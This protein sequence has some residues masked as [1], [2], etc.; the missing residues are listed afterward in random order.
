VYTVSE[1]TD[2]LSESPDVSVQ[3]TTVECGDY[4]SC[5]G[6]PDVSCF[7]GEAI[8]ITSQSSGLTFTAIWSE[9]SAPLLHGSR[10]I[11]VLPPGGF[12]SE[13][14]VRFTDAQR[15]GGRSFGIGPDF[16]NLEPYEWAEH[17][18]TFDAKFGG[19]YHPV[20]EMLPLPDA[21]LVYIQ[22]LES[23]FV[24]META[25]ICSNCNDES[26]D[27]TKTRD[28]PCSYSDEL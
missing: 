27:A 1:L 20:G 9:P 23:V 24:S 13:L 11:Y 12:A 26:C 25:L 14:H 19:H 21:I 5:A 15:I 10:D 28:S 18:E 17:S 16:V 6:F 8:Q 7:A 22:E 3:L 4:C 2:L